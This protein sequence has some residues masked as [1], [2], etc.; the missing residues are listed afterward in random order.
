MATV[1]HA[2]GVRDREAL[3]RQG[4]YRFLTGWSSPF[5]DPWNLVFEVGF[6]AAQS[7]EPFGL[8]AYRQILSNRVPVDIG[9]Y[10]DAVERLCGSIILSYRFKTERGV[11]HGI[12]LPRS[13]FIS[14][15]RSSPLLDKNTFYIPHF[16]NDTIEL[17][18][19]I[20]SQRENYKPRSADDQQFKHNGSRL[21]PPYASAYIARM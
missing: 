1:P 13:W 10:C 4:L 2:A 18:R 9:H 5:I 20:D 21:T 14:L 6:V 17:L 3:R 7:S 8:Y 15:L 16:V 19:R 11:L 12:T